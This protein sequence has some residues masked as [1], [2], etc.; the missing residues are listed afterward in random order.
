MIRYALICDQGHAFDAWFG[1]GAAYEDQERAHKVPCPCCGSV[2]V[3]KAPM[4]PA[5][6]RLMAGELG[7]DAARQSAEAAS[8]SRLARTYEL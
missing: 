4:A 3:E 7:W 8:F 2:A 6:A 1:S 5:V